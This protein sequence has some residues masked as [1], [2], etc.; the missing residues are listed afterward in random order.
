MQSRSKLAAILSGLKTGKVENLTENEIAMVSSIL[1]LNQAYFASHLERHLAAFR[2]AVWGRGCLQEAPRVG[3][4]LLIKAH[5]S[6][7]EF[8]KSPS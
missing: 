4:Q 3:A 1:N 6:Q 7:L 2:L 5:V 8:D